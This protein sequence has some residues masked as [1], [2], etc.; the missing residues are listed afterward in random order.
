MKPQPII[1]LT[2][3][4]QEAVKVA[5]PG[6]GTVFNINADFYTISQEAATGEIK[7]RPNFL[8][9]TS[10]L[11]KVY[12]QSLPADFRRKDLLEDLTENGLAILNWTYSS[13]GGFY[14]F[15][16]AGEYT[17]KVKIEKMAADPFTFNWKDK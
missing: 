2:G 4:A 8:P 17:G 5:L 6:L 11:V 1:K 3:A 10:Y 9:S 16:V 15:H 14:I 13:F 12:D 7:L